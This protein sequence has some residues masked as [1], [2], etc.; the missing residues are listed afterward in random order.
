MQTFETPGSVLLTIDNAVGEIVVDTEDVART[1]VDVVALRDDEVSRDA[2]A[3]TRV[4]QRPGE[5]VVEVPRR[6]GSF[7][8]RDPKVRVEVRAPVGS[9]V[10]FGTAS[11][12]VALRGRLS[13][14]RGKTASGDVTVGDCDA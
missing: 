5:I 3:G 1:T 7:L 11:A 4:E 8:G 14:I 9:S 13:D 12:D 6:H 10:A 2:V